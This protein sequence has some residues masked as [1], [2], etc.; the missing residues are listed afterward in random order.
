MTL[1]S[2]MSVYGRGRPKRT[3]RWS[4]IDRHTVFTT[5]PALNEVSANSTATASQ[6]QANIVTTYIRELPQ[7]GLQVDTP[8]PCIA[9]KLGDEDALATAPSVDIAA[10]GDTIDEALRKLADI[11][12]AKFSLYSSVDRQTLGP[13][14]AR[15]LNILR[16]HIS[17]RR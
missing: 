8:L 3:S 17:I 4:G 16:Q 10:S 14:P 2:K 15:Q 1:I 9:K 11:V 7:E 13:E 12:G 5:S 6:G